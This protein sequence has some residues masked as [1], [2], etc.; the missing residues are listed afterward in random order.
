MVRYGRQVRHEVA[1]NMNT[2]QQ[3]SVSVA[4]IINGHVTVEAMSRLRPWS[5]DTNVDRHLRVVNI[6][7]SVSTPL[8]V[9]FKR[10]DILPSMSTILRWS[11][12][13]RLQKAGLQH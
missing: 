10:F 9:D 2:C 1:M 4:V 13:E 7:L 3:P 5:S 8:R 12:D 6:L 11:D